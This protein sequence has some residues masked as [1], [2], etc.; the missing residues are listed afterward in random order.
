M[1]AREVHDAVVVGAGP[2]GLAGAVTLARAGLDV[3][4]LE[5]RPTV[6]GGARTLDLGLAPGI[7]HDICSAVHP[8]GLAS[9][10]LRAFDLQA[11]GVGLTVP[12]VSYAQPLEGRPA[13]LAYRDL[14]RT[15]EG[16]GADGRAWRALMG[17]LVEDA[18]AVIALVLGDHRSVPRELLRPSGARAAAAFGAAVL[19][20]GTRAW[21][22]RF[23]DDAGPALLSGVAAHSIST[24]PTL[25]AAGTSLMLGA[26]AH[27]VGW[28]LP[29][30]GSQAIVDALVS[31]LRA[32]GGEVRT[33]TRVT[34]WRELPRAR[35][36]LFD[37][38]PRTVAQVWGER[39]RPS[40]RAGLE[41]FRYGNAAA[42]VDFVLSGPV[43]WADARAGR[44]GTVHV[45][46]TR[47]EMAEAEAAVARGRHAERPMALLSDPAVFDPGR[48]VNGLRPL[49]TYAH[50]P[51]GSPVDVTET[52][53]AQI[54][55]FAPGFRDVVVASRCVPAAEMDQHN[56]SY[57][58]GDI[59]S[60][61]VTMWQMFARPR[62][63]WDVW[64]AGVPGVYLC[65][66]STVPGPGVHGMGGWHAARRALRHRFGIRKAPDLSPTA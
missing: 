27:A 50:V 12:D 55:R 57:I 34:H 38:T 2:N 15:A 64:G 22:A 66:Q 13:A 5:A 40:V 45:G 17:P 29:R 37:T 44:A 25:A 1:A 39:M 63:A 11:R 18:A 51:A 33:S 16:L 28:P 62:L 54:E 21:N 19:E 42:K 9:P 32:H 60:G 48:V 30:G 49:W 10:F 31:D 8:L 52:L 59:A 3:L 43:P 47:A 53:T 14:A 41:R 56:P 35:A 6:G 7:V 23:S 26:L 61:A 4:V 58:G 20:Q 36:Y 46:G 65:S 24:L